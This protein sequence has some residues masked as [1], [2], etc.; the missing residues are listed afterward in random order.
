MAA[1]PVI[2]EVYYE[3]RFRSISKSGYLDLF[4]FSLLSRLSA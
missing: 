4:L 2:R 3:L 1:N